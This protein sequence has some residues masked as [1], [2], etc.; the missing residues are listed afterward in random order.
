M[1][2]ARVLAFIA[3]LLM[4]MTAHASAEEA[5]LAPTPPKARSGPCVAPPDVMRRTHMTMLKHQRDDTV[6]NGVRGKPEGL[7]NCITCHA[8]KDKDGGFVT[9]KSPLHFCRTCHDYAAVQVDCFECHASRPETG[10]V[11]NT[12]APK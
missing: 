3:V 4:A 7:T 12:E 5:T 11:P 2:R 6:H 10:N 9:A 8:V 1:M